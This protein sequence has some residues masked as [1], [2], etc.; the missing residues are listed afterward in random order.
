VEQLCEKEFV[1]LVRGL[2]SEESRSSPA[3]GELFVFPKTITRVKI[4][5]GMSLDA[6]HT[7]QW[8]LADPNLLVIGF[9]P[10][11]RC[12][13]S[14]EKIFAQAPLGPSFRRRLWLL[15]LALGSKN[16]WAKFFHC[17]DPGQ[18][19]IYLPKKFQILEEIIVPQAKLDL[20][21]NQLSFSEQ[22]QRID[23]VKTDCQGADF[24]I[25]IGASQN[26]HRIAIWTSEAD[27]LGYSR[28]SNK[29]RDLLKFFK[30]AGFTWFNQRSQLRVAIGKIIL[31]SR[32][33][34]LYL[35]LT[36]ALNK[37]YQSKS[38]VVASTV[39]IHVEDATFVNSRF[40]EEIARREITAFQQG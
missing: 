28:S 24:E 18:S 35:D 40:S 21:L 1:T 38:E 4:D 13:E 31:G 36:S 6:G 2:L 19:S 3:A 34:Q 12:R 11:T 14:I 23:H 20:V 5:V 39:D 10:L 7:Q 32:F 27:S 30:K 16:S 15:P 8:L 29:S 25:A 37:A 22:V 33:H 17:E 9:E 26:L